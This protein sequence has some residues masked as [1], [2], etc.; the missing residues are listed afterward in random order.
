MSKELKNA[1]SNRTRYVR[2]VVHKV[3]IQLIV[4]R[5]PLFC[6]REA[7][8]LHEWRRQMRDRE[9]VWIIVRSVHTRLVFWLLRYSRLEEDIQRATL[10]C[11]GLCLRLP[12]RPKRAS[13]PYNLKHLHAPA[14]NKRNRGMWEQRGFAWENT[15]PPGIRVGEYDAGLPQLRLTIG[16]E[17]MTP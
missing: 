9:R 11:I 16:T 4:H 6:W 14:L 3:Q 15:K 7:K 8:L 13:C 5:L 1:W 10:H 2:L 17:P 12:H